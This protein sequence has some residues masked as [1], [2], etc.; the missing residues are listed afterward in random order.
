MNLQ[1]INKSLRDTFETK[2]TEIKL[3]NEENTVLNENL[4]KNRA[5]ETENTKLKK[6]NEQLEIWINEQKQERSE[7]IVN[8]TA[9]F[10]ENK[11]LS[12]SNQDI[13]LELSKYNEIFETLEKKIEYYNYNIT[14]I[15]NR[16]NTK[17]TIF[18]RI[19]ENYNRIYDKGIACTS[20][21]TKVSNI[22]EQLLS[23]DIRKNQNTIEKDIAT[24]FNI[25][26][27]QN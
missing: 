24:S 14:I 26:M 3:L 11:R 17:K 19:C 2:N 13:D 16:D 1:D 15:L 21:G 10:L 6:I 7:I 5:L 12:S 25:N 9:L 27:F 18:I 22:L 20:R 4:A 23:I 8:A